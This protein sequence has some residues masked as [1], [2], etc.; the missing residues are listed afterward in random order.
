MY[1]RTDDR[2][3]EAMLIIALCLVV[4]V[5]YGAL[6][7]GY[8]VLITKPAA[9]GEFSRGLLSAAYGGAVLTG[10]IAA[11]P[12]GR[13]AD[14]HGV[15]GV[16]AAGAVVGAAGLLCFASATAGWQVLAA[17]WLL[18]GPATAMCFYEPAYVAIQQ[19]FAPE[20][21]AQAI[22]LLT[23]TAGLS[24]PIFT[25]T[26]CA[27]SPQSVG[28]T[29][30]ACSRPRCSARLRWRCC[31]SGSARARAPTTACRQGTRSA[32]VALRQPHVLLFTLGAV[33]AYGAIEAVVL[34]RIAR[35][36]ELGSGLGT[37]A[38]WVGIAGVLTRPVLAASMRAGFR[39][40]GCCPVCSASWDCRL[41]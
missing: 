33:L 24:G 19:A 32:R 17:W 26:T 25:P 28:A 2:A 29:R 4:T 1:D 20:R 18:L 34:H 36:Q 41:R 38:L 15:R 3:G 22:G 30:R 7:Y 10:G 35:F 8:A 5:A 6:Y 13:T 40:P 21:R 16:M 11:V 12:V 14:R 31:S 23:L 27:S 39:L 9:G 37:V